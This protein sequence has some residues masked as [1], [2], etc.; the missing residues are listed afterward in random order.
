MPLRPT[1]SW[2]LHIASISVLNCLLMFSLCKS[3]ETLTVCWKRVSFILHYECLTE[4]S[5][6]LNCSSTAEFTSFRREGFSSFPLDVSDFFD[7]TYH[8]KRTFQKF[9]LL[10]VVL[11]FFQHF[12]L[13]LVAVG[14]SDS[15]PS[16]F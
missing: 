5:S 4:A 6:G 1:D 13:S 9:L 14:T 2:A 7:E 16:P 15:L 11:L 8:T 10:D 3:I 12:L